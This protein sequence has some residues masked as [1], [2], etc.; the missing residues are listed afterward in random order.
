MTYPDAEGRAADISNGYKLGVCIGKIISLDPVLEGV[1][2]QY[3]FG[4]KWDG[5]WIEWKGRDNAPYVETVQPNQLLNQQ[6]DPLFPIARLNF[7][8][9]QRAGAKLDQPSRQMAKKIHACV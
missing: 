2:I 6:N 4:T 1:T 3:L 5:R 9:A 7:Q 8:K